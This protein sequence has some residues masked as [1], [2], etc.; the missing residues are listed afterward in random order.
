SSNP[1]ADCAGGPGQCAAPAS[2]NDWNDFVAAVASRYKGRIKYYELWNE[3]NAARFW[4][5]ST[6]Q[7]VQMA[8]LAYS[9]I[10]QADPDALVLTPA[11]QGVN[12]YR[13]TE[14]YFAAGGAAFAYMVAFHSYPGYDQN[15]HANRPE[16]W[17]N[18]LLNMNSAL[19][20]HRVHKPLWDTEFSW[21]YNDRLPG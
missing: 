12:A 21:E 15:N 17:I 5:G 11:P 3:P 6:Q 13:W 20:L 7:M 14:A 10:K 16:T 18:V 1:S 2:M 19:A 4:T 9:T 8:K